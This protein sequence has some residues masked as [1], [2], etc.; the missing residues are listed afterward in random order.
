MA[1]E[2]MLI[3]LPPSGAKVLH[4]LLRGQHQPQNVR[5]L[6]MKFFFRHRFERAN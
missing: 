1:S 5:V 4:R 3:T 2:L 6:A